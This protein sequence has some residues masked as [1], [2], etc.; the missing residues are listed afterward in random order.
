MDKMPE[1]RYIYYLS[2]TARMVVRHDSVGN[3]I[4]EFSVQLE[5][6]IDGRWR[7]A[8]RYDSAHGQPHRHV[9]YP[10]KPEYR[11]VMVHDDNNLA[12]TE[13]QYMIKTSFQTLYERYKASYERMV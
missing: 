1:K 5:V 12:Y 8:V 7:K 11:E 9:F 10:D 2:D 6:L 4:L 3:T 13:A